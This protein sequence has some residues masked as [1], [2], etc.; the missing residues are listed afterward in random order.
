MIKELTTPPGV[1]WERRAGNYKRHP[2]IISCARI[3]CAISLL[4]CVDIINSE[5]SFLFFLFIPRIAV[6]RISRKCCSLSTRHLTLNFHGRKA[7]RSY[8]LSTCNKR[9]NISRENNWPDRTSIYIY[10]S[11]YRSYIPSQGG[12]KKTSNRTRW[13]P[14]SKRQVK[15]NT[16]FCNPSTQYTTTSDYK[17]NGNV[18]VY[19]GRNKKLSYRLERTRSICIR[20]YSRELFPL[21][22]P[23][24]VSIYQTS[25]SAIR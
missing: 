8:F 11:T 20:M 7:L 21:I 23:E 16:M 6:N 2:V 4:S 14:P 12:S 15:E 18:Y 22:L 9:T 3:S 17:K 1:C 25:Y 10:Y 5:V 13:G 24:K 19:L